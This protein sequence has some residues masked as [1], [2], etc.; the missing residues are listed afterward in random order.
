MLVETTDDR[1]CTKLGVIPK[2]TAHRANGARTHAY[3]LL[4]IYHNEKRLT[5]VY[6]LL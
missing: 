2:D 6:D 1:S 4:G 5:L 3:D